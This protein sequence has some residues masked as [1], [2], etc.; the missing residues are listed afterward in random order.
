[1]EVGLPKEVSTPSK[2]AVTRRSRAVATRR[3]KVGAAVIPHRRVE[4]MAEVR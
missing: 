3:R 2:A 4:V 1:M